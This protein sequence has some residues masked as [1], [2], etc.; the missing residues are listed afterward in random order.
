MERTPLEH[1]LLKIHEVGAVKFGQFKLKS[2]VI[3]PI[4]IDIRSIVSFPE[5][6]NL[7]CDLMWETLSTRC[8]G[9]LERTDF[10]AGVPYTALPI[11]SVLA[12][13]REF[14]MLIVRKERKAYGTGREVEG[15]FRDGQTCLLIEDVCVSGAS[16]LEARSRVQ[17]EGL[18][19]KNAIVFIDRD[20]GGIQ[21]LQ[22]HGVTLFKVTC[23][24][25]LV[26]TLHK[27][28]RIDNETRQ[29]VVDFVAA[30]QQAPEI[31]TSVIPSDPNSN[32]SDNNNN[33]S[34][35]A[36]IDDP[37]AKYATLTFSARAGLSKSAFSR[38]LFHLMDAKKTNLCVAADVTSSAH[39]LRLADELGP[40]ICMLKTQVDLLEDWDPSLPEKLSQLAKKHNFVLFEDRRFTHLGVTV[41]QQY[42]KGLYKI[43]SWAHLTDTHLIAGASS[44]AALSEACLE[45]VSSHPD[46][47]PRGLLLLIQTK[48]IGA[49]L[50][51]TESKAIAEALTHAHAQ[52]ISGYICQERFS[53]DSGVL[54]CTPGVYLTAAETSSGAEKSSTSPSPSL[55]SADSSS[56]KQYRT[57]E[58]AIIRSRCDVIIV[59]RSIVQSDDPVAIAR[60]YRNRAWEAHF[61]KVSTQC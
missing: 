61:K 23:M 59:G 44:V 13:T 14:P 57:P 22:N 52:T 30:N 56:T 38:H 19:V 4:Y 17:A 10:L 18:V 1:L 51:P 39:L 16:I 6:L 46:A 3:T 53:T 45:Q 55:A 25:D 42:S 40:E 11:A 47:G 60:E 7:L 32:A 49:D 33:A 5:I 20:Q 34:S 24:V 21:H 28:G 31:P 58:E 9:V 2:G 29:S 37:I 54:Y 50:A 15:V 48:A 8:E 36:N 27:F 35:S 12:V 41:K 26:H 43:G